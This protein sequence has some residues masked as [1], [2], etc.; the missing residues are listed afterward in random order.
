MRES[1]NRSNKP[2]LSNTKSTIMVK[3]ET[4]SSGRNKRNHFVAK[5]FW[6]LLSLIVFNANVIAQQSEKKIT[7]EFK[8]ERLASAFKKIEDASGYKFIFNYEDI[9]AYGVTGSIKD[10]TIVETLDQV[11]GNKPLVYQIE[12][13]FITIALKP[14]SPEAKAKA[15]LCNLSGIVVDNDKHPLPGA[16][17]IIEGTK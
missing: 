10:K 3:I 17:V 4:D 2:S 8:N 16:H 15:R 6:L 13:K 14:G 5:A 9:F 7:L 12:G 1:F 11:I